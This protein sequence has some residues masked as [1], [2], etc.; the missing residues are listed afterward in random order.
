MNAFMR[1]ERKPLDC[2]FILMLGSRLLQ[3]RIEHSIKRSQFKRP[4]IIYKEL[5]IS[6]QIIP[7]PKKQQQIAIKPGCDNENESRNTYD[8]MQ[9]T[10]GLI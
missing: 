6:S 5:E 2:I 3:T 8:C 4:S 9:I 1:P 10:E 7:Q